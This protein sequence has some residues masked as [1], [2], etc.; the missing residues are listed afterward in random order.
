MRDARIHG[1]PA[2][3]RGLRHAFGVAAVLGYAD[4]STTAA[5]AEAREVV[6]RAWS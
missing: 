6:A 4:L 5:G 2:C 3:P 1:P